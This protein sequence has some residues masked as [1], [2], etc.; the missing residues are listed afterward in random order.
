VTSDLAVGPKYR[1]H[2]SCGATVETSEQKE[3][4][5]AC[6]NSIEVLAVSTTPRGE[7]YSLRIGR[8]RRD[9]IQEPAAWVPPPN[10][11][12]PSRRRFLPPDTN[13]R[14][15]RLGLMILLA[16][17]Y[18]PLL[19][20]SME[21]VA[22][23]VYNSQTATNP[24]VITEPKPSDCGLF[25]DCHYVERRSNDKHTGKTIITWERIQD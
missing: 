3:V 25:S 4:C 22:T 17:L 2:C 20:A 24:T 11:D 5:S 21:F 6:G 14:Y 18:V 23:Q 7:K 12:L 16:P 8:H 13:E 10:W 15:L 1:Y 9:A 19:L